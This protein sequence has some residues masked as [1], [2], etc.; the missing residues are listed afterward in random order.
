MSKMGELAFELAE[1]WYKQH[2]TST[3][4]DAMEAVCNEIYDRTFQK[5][6]DQNEDS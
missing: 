2:P 6:G 1:K 4:E 3:W 5:E